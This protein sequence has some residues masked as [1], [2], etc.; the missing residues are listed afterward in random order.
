MDMVMRIKQGSMVVD[1]E[2]EYRLNFMLRL[3]IKVFIRVDYLIII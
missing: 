3:G 2:L 1:W